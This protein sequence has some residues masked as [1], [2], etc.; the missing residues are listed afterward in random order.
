MSADIEKKGKHPLTEQYINIMGGSDTLPIDAVMSLIGPMLKLHDVNA[1]LFDWEMD[2]EVHQR[3]QHI[4]AERIRAAQS[5]RQSTLELLIGILN[6]DVR[7]YFHQTAEDETGTPKI[8]PVPITQWTRSMAHAVKKFK[9]TTKTDPFGN[10]TDTYNLEFHEPHRAIEQLKDLAP[11]VFDLV[12]LDD[13][14]TID[15]T[16]LEK[17]S[18]DELNELHARLIRS[19]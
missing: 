10:T 2:P 7:K 15:V 1:V 13:G 14:N 6:A 12:K 8:K 4:R 9:Y 11:E 16:S 19:F 3:I 5:V 18:D 17:L